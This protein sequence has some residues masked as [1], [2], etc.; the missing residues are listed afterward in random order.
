MH[1]VKPLDTVSVLKAAKKTGAVLTIEDH[2][3][4]NGLGGAVSETLGENYPVP[5][6]RMGLPDVFAESGSYEELLEK[7]GLGINSIVDESL[8]LLKR[9]GTK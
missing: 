2:N 8:K 6:R 3:I 1:T 9:K 7:Y 4:I 5:I